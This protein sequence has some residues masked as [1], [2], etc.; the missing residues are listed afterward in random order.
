MTE[1][2]SNTGDS[3]ATDTS[4]DTDVDEPSKT[5]T[6]E[7]LEKKIKRRTGKLAS[8][9]ETLKAQMTEFETFK[10]DA[11][12][13][14]KWKDSQKSEMDRIKEATAS[15]KASREK[16]ES[17]LK[18]L[19][20]QIAKDKLIGDIASEQRLPSSLTKYVTGSTK[21]EILA[22]VKK[23]KADFGLKDNKGNHIPAN[24]SNAALTENQ[25]MNGFLVGMV[26]GGGR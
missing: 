10:T 7:Q 23:I 5:Y 8:E 4:D 18:A 3:A 26:R 16:A 22:S 19:R 15:E 9:N 6:Q 20:E 13:Y 17:D 25:E 11:L 2:T 14:R 21:E 12:E 24:D 1:D